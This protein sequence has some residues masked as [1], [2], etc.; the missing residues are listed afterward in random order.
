[1][2]KPI[3]TFVHGVIDYVTVGT[4]ASLPH[5][6]GA[7]K[8]TTMLLTGAAA[9]ILT[10]SLLTDYDLGLFDV[11]PMKGHLALDGVSAATLLAAPLM[12]RGN[13][14]MNAAILGIVASEIVVTALTKTQ[15]TP[16]SRVARFLNRK[17]SA[18][19]K[20][21]AAQWLGK[22]AWWRAA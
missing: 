3:T 20:G 15:P 9:S 17:T 11:I 8:R 2:K 14:K 1:M 12:D 10:Y 5:I 22:V 4:L 6:L 18:K 16:T 19:T 13:T 21:K 7:N